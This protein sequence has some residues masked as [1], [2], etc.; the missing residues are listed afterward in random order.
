MVYVYSWYAA[1]VWNDFLGV[2]KMF[3]AFLI[4]IGHTLDSMEVWAHA[5]APY[6]KCF[7]KQLPYG[8]DI[9]KTSRP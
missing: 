9:L 7:P 2:N 1:Q 4:R 3:R 5:M 8:G 6:I